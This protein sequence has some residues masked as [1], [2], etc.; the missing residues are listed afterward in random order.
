VEKYRVFVTRKIPQEGLELI[1][2][3]CSVEVSD[4]QG[5]I[6]REVLLEKVQGNM[7]SLPSSRIPSTGK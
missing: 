1:G 4:F 3:Y 2:E 6:P 7:V 5:M